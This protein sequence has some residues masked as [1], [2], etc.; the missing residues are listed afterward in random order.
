M[1]KRMRPILNGPS[2]LAG[3]RIEPSLCLFLPDEAIWVES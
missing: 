2:S 1:Q 3:S